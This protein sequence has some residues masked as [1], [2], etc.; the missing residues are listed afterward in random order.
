MVPYPDP[1]EWDVIT[2]RLLG[3][4]LLRPFWA[5]WVRRLDLRGGERVLDFGS[6]SGQL[7]RRLA[8]AVGP[9]GGLTCV[10]VSPGWLTIAREELSD[11]AWVDLRLGDLGTLPAAAYDLVHVH[12]VL[13]DIP[14]GRRGEVLVELAARLRAGGRLALREPLYY[15]PFRLDEIVEL[16]SRVGLVLTDRPRR[17]WWLAGPVVEA[18]FRTR[19]GAGSGGG[20]S[21]W[22]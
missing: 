22:R 15:G 1:A 18:V 12:Y 21:A 16:L 7:S 6:G 11:L 20:G 2:T 9:S 5:G 8:L 13:H 3:R 4:T 14:A 10:D 19:P 17:R